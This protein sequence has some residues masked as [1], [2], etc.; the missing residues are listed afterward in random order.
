MHTWRIVNQF[1]SFLFLHW[2]C[3]NQFGVFDGN[4]WNILASANLTLSVARGN[5][6]RSFE[7]IDWQ[8]FYCQNQTILPICCHL[9]PINRL[10]SFSIIQTLCGLSQDRQILLIVMHTCLAKHSLRPFL[11]YSMFHHASTRTRHFCLAFS[12]TL[13]RLESKVEQIAM[14]ST[15]PVLDVI[16][17]HKEIKR[18]QSLPESLPTDSTLIDQT[19]LISICSFGSL[20]PI[21]SSARP[22]AS[23]Q[24][25]WRLLR[26]SYIIGVAFEPDRRHL[27]DSTSPSR[28]STLT[29]HFRRL[30]LSTCLLALNSTTSVIRSFTRSFN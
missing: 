21:T 26:E 28:S 10:R 11:S 20:L 29:L 2:K 3:C 9:V 27:P 13:D 24:L 5:I 15:H 12:L 22:S 1:R 23:L 7:T 30:T 17:A 18:M 14:S 4:F 25:V 19:K 8:H 16:W 6:D